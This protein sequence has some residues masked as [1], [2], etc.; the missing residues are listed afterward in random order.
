ME[1]FSV[2][3]DKAGEFIS[4][5]ATLLLTAG[6]VFGTVATAA[7][8]GRASFKAA[9]ILAKQEEEWKTAAIQYDVEHDGHGELEPPT[10][11]DK[12]KAVGPHYLPA[13][14]VGGG[15]I[16]AIIFSHRMSNAKIAGL[17]AAYGLAERNLSE[18]KEKVAEKLTGPKKQAI[19]EELSQD[20]VN[21]A[22][23]PPNTMV[24]VEGEVLCFD[25]ATDRYFHSTMEKIRS[26]AN[27]INAQILSEDYAD[28]SDFY[29]QLGLKGTKWSS[30]VG[31]N[32]D[33]M[34]E[35]KFDTVTAPDG[36]PC[37]AIEFANFPRQDFIRKHY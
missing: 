20:R 14:V 36:R 28:A 5:N 11:L 32:T 9:E 10:K 25:E 23:T 16:A 21:R 18:Y 4:E 22:G 8:T 7:L 12:I 19:G 27:K 34:L 2:V 15:T 33:H 30:E 6:G 17:V 29:H 24:I 37:I 26:A 13:V 35:L 3:K 1:F 31:W